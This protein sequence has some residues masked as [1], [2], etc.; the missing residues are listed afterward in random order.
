MLKC[1]LQANYK[2]DGWESYIVCYRGSHTLTNSPHNIKII[3]S[4]F[5]IG[6]LVLLSPPI[7]NQEPGPTEHKGLTICRC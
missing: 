5:I 6:L 2:V 4:L 1:T 3:I 7:E